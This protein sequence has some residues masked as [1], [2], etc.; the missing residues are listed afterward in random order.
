M[1]E[2]KKTAIELLNIYGFL[3]EMN[4]YNNI[5]I[6]GAGMVGKHIY[7]YLKNNLIADR[8]RSFFVSEK[9]ESIID[10]IQVKQIN[11]DDID[12]HGIVLLAAKYNTR[13]ELI[14]V[15]KKI[16]VTNT[17]EITVFD[18]RDYRYYS[19]IPEIAYPIELKLWYK[20]ITSKELNLKNPRTFNEKINWTKLYDRNPM[21]TMLTDKVLVRKWVEKKIGKEYL[22]P[23][24]GQWENPEEI[25]Y[26]KLPNSFIIKCNHGCGYNILVKDKKEMNVAEIKSKLNTWLKTNYAFVSG[27]E[28]QYK[29]IDPQ[30]LVE[31]LLPLDENNDLPDY[32]FFCFDGQVFCSYV[33]VDSQKEHDEGILG[34]FDKSFNQMP[35]FRTSY[36]PMLKYNV[37]KPQNYQKMVEIAETLSKGFS[38]VRVDLYNIKGKIFFGEMTFSTASGIGFFEPNEFDLIM[39]SKW[40]LNCFNKIDD[41]VY[42]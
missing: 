33:R 11:K 12:C 36:K 1:K 34:F 17:K 41:G 9:V 21:K 14:S 24:F 32:K 25:D 31:E 26:D 10:N 28:L 6:F 29:N 27:F 2:L 5:Y 16:D 42:I 23:C 40:S 30:I 19:T 7:D 15:C 38:H 4:K 13:K 3:D 20:T 37:E 22:I 18:D 35:Y 8:V 39:G